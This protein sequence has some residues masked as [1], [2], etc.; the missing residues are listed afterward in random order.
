MAGSPASPEAYM[1]GLDEPRR[2][3]VRRLHELIR[4]TAPDLQPY[5]ER[6]GG[7]AMIGYGRYHHRYPT[8]MEGDWFRV[9]L[10]GRKQYT[11]LYIVAEED[12]RYLA[13]AW[14]DRLGKVDVGKSCIR[15]KRLQDVDLGQI[16]AL[17]RRAAS[18]PAPG[19]A[20]EA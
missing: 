20:A 12:G 18:S 3:E 1:E 5:I 15:I 2:S 10:A 17:L 14:A 13:E 7:S 4:G 9:G 19:E 11:A 8:G 16:E 6:Y